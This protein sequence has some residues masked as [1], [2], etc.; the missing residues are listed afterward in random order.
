M[1]NRNS[2]PDTEI[3]QGNPEAE[4]AVPGEGAGLEERDH[5]GRLD[6][7]GDP[8]VHVTGPARKDRL[9]AG[10]EKNG[11]ADGH[12]LHD[13]RTDGHGEGYPGQV[14]E[15]QNQ[16]RVA[17]R[18]E[19]QGGPD[20]HGHEEGEHAHGAADHLGVTEHGKAALD[21]QHLGRYHRH[22]GADESG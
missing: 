5:Q 19:G 10:I 20:H 3:R 14:V 17:V 9:G 12:V 7:G 15:Q 1:K 6:G 16:L 18:A 21:A 2:Y 4:Q 11:D 22:P 8:E 13:G